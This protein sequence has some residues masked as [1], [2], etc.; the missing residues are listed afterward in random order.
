MIL[1]KPAFFYAG[2]NLKGVY[3]PAALLRTYFPSKVIP[4]S[5]CDGAVHL[6]YKNQSK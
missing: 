3:F 6:F 4:R 2:F 1:K 5:L